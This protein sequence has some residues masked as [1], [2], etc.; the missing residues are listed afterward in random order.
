M[1]GLGQMRLIV[2]LKRPT[3]YDEQLDGPFLDKERLDA[4]WQT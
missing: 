1:P 3:V 4:D 2:L